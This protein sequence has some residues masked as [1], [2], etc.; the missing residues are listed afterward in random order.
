MRVLLCVFVEEAVIEVYFFQT[1]ERM[2]AM[3]RGP[4]H[5]CISDQTEGTQG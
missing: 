1:G 3:G 2:G 4:E 5:L